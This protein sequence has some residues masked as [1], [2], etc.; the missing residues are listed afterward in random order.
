MPLTKDDFIS[1]PIGTIYHTSRGEGRCMRWKKNGKTQ[2]WKTRPD[3]FRMPVKHG[4]YVYDAVTPDNAHMV[5]HREDDC[6]NG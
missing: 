5:I 2:T 6:P 3:E 1:D 4:L